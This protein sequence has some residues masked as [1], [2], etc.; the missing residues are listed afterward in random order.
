MRIM[1]WNCCGG[2]TTKA[3]LKYFN[4]FRPDL[5]ILQEV[6]EPNLKALNATDTHFVTNNFKSKNEKGLA[7]LAFNGWKIRVLPS[8]PDFEVFVPAVIYNENFEFNLLAI[9]SFN[10]RCKQGRFVGL[11]DQNLKELAFDHYRSLLADPCLVAGDWNVGATMPEWKSEH[12]KINAKLDGIGFTSLYH[13]ST[14]EAQGEEK[15]RTLISRK[16]GVKH[17]ID[18]MHG[19]DYFTRRMTRFFVDDFANVPGSDHTPLVLDIEES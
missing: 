8:D 18:H 12:L 14:G 9:W 2:L 15:L 17:V 7:I 6:G 11:K 1:S 10:S 4:S 13:H 5:A 19:S 16:N 3:K